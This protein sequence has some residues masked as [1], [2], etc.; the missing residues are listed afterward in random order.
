MTI[1]TSAPR[2]GTMDVNEFQ[3]FLETRP[4]EERWQL[5][6]GVAV[7]MN[8]PTYVHQRISLNFSM[9]LNTA[10]AAQNSELF[11]YIEVGVR[12]PNVN[13]F[14]PRP[15][16]VVTSGTASYI[17]F[18]ENFSLVAEVLSPTNTAREISLKLQRYRE[19][20]D[21]S[22][23]F[24][25]DSRRVSIEIHARKHEWKARKLTSLDESIELPEFGFHCKAGDLYR[26]TPLNPSRRK[27][28]Q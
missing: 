7:M 1:A 3:A 17:T 8:P 26:G 12:A 20:P 23:V 21:N 14:Q 18:E 9:L 16:I 15:D 2:P 13:N 28:S 25:I 27:E 4:K 22:Y 24:V 11:A 5:I 19:A 10:F 6:E